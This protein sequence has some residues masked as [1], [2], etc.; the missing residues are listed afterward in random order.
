MYNRVDFIFRQALSQPL[1]PTKFGKDKRRKHHHWKV[2]VFFKGGDRFA[3]IYTDRKRTLGFAK[4]Q[5]K[6]PVVKL[7]RVTEVH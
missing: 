2:T 6:S 3:R 7:A 4:R 5:R 1:K